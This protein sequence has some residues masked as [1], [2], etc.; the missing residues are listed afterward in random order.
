MLLKPCSIVVLTE[1]IGTNNY[2]LLAKYKKYNMIYKF[3]KY[4]SD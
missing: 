2:K 4:E 3:V 1:N